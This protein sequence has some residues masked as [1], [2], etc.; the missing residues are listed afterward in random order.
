[1]TDRTG[2]L[3]KSPL[4]YALASIRFAPWPLMVEKINAIHDELRHITPLIKQVQIHQFNLSSQGAHAEKSVAS[5]SWMFMSSDRSH[6]FHLTPDQLLVFSSKYLRYVDFLKIIT[7]GLDVLFKHMQFMD[8]VNIGVRYVDHI[9]MCEGKKPQ[10]YINK[11]LLPSEFDGFKH[12][13]GL[14]I[15]SYEVD[16]VELRVRCDTQPDALSIPED[17]IGI[18]AMAQEPST[19]FQLKTLTD[20]EFLLDMDAIKNYPTPQRMT[21]NIAIIEKITYLHQIANNF[22]RHKDVC[23][24]YAFKLWKGEV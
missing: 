9:I 21:D 10:D 23:T 24:D 5:A 4:V 1:M 6:G 2:I 14:I 18:L 17:M 11:G 20:R 8:V 7:E 19:P 16:D 15:G 22:F 12:K 13:G 3:N